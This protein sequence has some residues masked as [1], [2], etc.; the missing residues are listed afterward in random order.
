MAD[1]QLILVRHDAG[2]WQF[3]IPAGNVSFDLRSLGYGQQVEI[4]APN[5]QFI[6]D[7]GGYY[8]IEVRGDTSALIVR[9]GGHATLAMQGGRG[10]RH[11]CRRKL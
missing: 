9:N 8:R 10:P 6:V 11:K 2:Y 3:R 7:R 1:S 4:D 5:A